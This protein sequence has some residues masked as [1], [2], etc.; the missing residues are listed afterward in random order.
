ML[1]RDVWKERVGASPY[2]SHSRKELSSVSEFW[3]MC[4]PKWAARGPRRQAES[5]LGP[6]P[7]RIGWSRRRQ[8][9]RAGLRTPGGRDKQNQKPVQFTQLAYNHYRKRGSDARRYRQEDWN[10]LK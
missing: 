2:Q 1:D 10:I 7:S 6:R 8:C 4:R 3:G 5:V 9:Y